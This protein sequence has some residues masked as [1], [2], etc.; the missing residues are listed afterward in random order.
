L[1]LPFSCLLETVSCA[2]WKS[3]VGPVTTPQ[4][5]IIF[6]STAAASDAMGVMFL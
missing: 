4:Q 2:T 1:P 3:C 5:V 6:Y